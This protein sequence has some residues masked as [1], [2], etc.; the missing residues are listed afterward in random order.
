M[1]RRPCTIWIIS[2]RLL[3]STNKRDPN[4]ERTCLE[5]HAIEVGLGRYIFSLGFKGTS[6]SDD[7]ICP[8]N[9]LTPGAMH[10]T[11]FFALF[12]N[13]CKVMTPT[14]YSPFYKYF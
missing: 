11:N 3:A 7:S 14:F 2:V 9:T 4:A 10:I 5:A 6:E 8:C 1:V 12:A 13:I